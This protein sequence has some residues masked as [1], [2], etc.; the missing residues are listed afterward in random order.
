MYAHAGRK[1]VGNEYSSWIVQLLIVIRFVDIAT[2]LTLSDC[3]RF[4]AK[5]SR[6]H[7]FFHK[8]SE[9]EDTVHFSIVGFSCV[10]DSHLLCAHLCFTSLYQRVELPNSYTREPIPCTDPD[11]QKFF[12]TLDAVLSGLETLLRILGTFYEI[13]IHNKLSFTAMAFWF[14]PPSA[15]L[16]DPVAVS[17]GELFA[18]NF[19]APS[20][21]SGF[22]Q[23]LAGN[24]SMQAALGHQSQAQATLDQPTARST[25]E[26]AGAL[27]LSSAHQQRAQQQPVNLSF[28]I[29]P[30]GFYVCPQTS[31]QT[32]P[33]KHKVDRR[34]E[35][36]LIEIFQGR[37]L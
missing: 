29:V 11:R 20:S 10:A 18:P 19:T 21:A 14:S 27:V 28:K 8:P 25:P 24:L 4:L 23:L 36:M 35:F 22:F 37:F 9:S 2:S 32:S 15:A 3:Q 16:F 12:K 26:A 31:V 33:G 1:N 6:H 7:N 13:I 34:S 17:R 30:V 5:F